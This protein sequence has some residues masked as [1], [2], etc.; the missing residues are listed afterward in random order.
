MAQG[1]DGGLGHVCSEYAATLL[2]GIGSPDDHD[3][4]SSHLSLDT[5]RPTPGRHYPALSLG[6]IMLKN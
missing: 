4:R 1:W 2:P 5:L 3:L 6:G